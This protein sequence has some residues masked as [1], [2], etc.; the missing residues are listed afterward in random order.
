[1]TL[2]KQLLKLARNEDE[3][4]IRAFEGAFLSDHDF[5]A[6]ESSDEGFD[7]DFFLETARAIVAVATAPEPRALHGPALLERALLA[8]GAPPP[9]RLLN[10]TRPLP[11]PRRREAGA[12]RRLFSRASDDRR[13]G[14][15]AAATGG[16]G[17]GRCTARVQN[18]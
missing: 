17:G 11:A 12:R 10:R 7:V 1:M 18:G 14:I 13:R 4:I 3:A 9:H 8:V 5:A 16:S 6:G 15:L 2:T